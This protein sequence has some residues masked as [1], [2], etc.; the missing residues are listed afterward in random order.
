MFDW[1]PFY[2]DG[3]GRCASRKGAIDGKEKPGTMDPVA[4][5]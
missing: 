2:S 5:G 1:L 4:K 3:E